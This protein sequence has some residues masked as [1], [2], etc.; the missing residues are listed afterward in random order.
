M[1]SMKYVMAIV[2]LCMAS[3]LRAQTA[4]YNIMD[5]PMVYVQGGAYNMGAQVH[6]TLAGA[7]E[8]THSVKVKNFYISPC[9]V[10]QA[11]WKAVMGNNPSRFKGETRPV[12]RV[13]WNDCQLFID[14]LNKLTGMH[15]RLP[16]EAEW[17]Y[18]AKGGHAYSRNW[19]SGAKFVNTVARYKDNSNHVTWKV[20]TRMPNELNLCDMSGNVWE[21]CADVYAPYDTTSYYPKS[22][23]EGLYRV[24]RGGSYN[25]TA[26]DCRVSKRGRQKPN[27]KH[28]TIGFRLAMSDE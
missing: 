23:A 4:P 24:C 26:A 14:S 18:A 21:W 9:E 20:S 3:G 8:I 2:L 19:Y 12:E 10:T 17:E 16:T 22:P 25:S 15:Y 5:I 13:S 7:D 6:D 27:Y 11:L 1:N 28:P